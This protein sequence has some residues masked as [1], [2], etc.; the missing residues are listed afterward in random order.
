MKVPIEIYDIKQQKLKQAEVPIED[1]CPI[2]HKAGKLEFVC[3]S[4]SVRIVNTLG[5]LKI[6]F[7]KNN[8]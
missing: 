7:F 3:H 5:R 1:N 8:G 6:S 4:I 2:C